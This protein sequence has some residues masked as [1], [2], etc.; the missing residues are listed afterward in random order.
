MYDKFNTRNNIL[1][2]LKTSSD[3][4]VFIDPTSTYH[5][6]GLSEFAPEPIITVS[7]FKAASI[8]ALVGGI[9]NDAGYGKVS[10]LAGDAGRGYHAPFNV[11]IEPTIAGAPGSNAS[12][13]LVGFDKSST[14]EYLWSRAYETINSGSGYLPNLNRVNEYRIGN[15]TST[16]QQSFFGETSILVKSGSTIINDVTYG[17]GNRKEIVFDQLN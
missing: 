8:G 3:A 2:F 10:I 4:V 1:N 5:T 7:E 14:S 11:K 15:P 9:L 17:T 13:K 16:S 12:F 6:F